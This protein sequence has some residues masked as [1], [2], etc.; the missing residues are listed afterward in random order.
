MG[1]HKIKVT[2]SG[3]STIKTVHADSIWH[4]IAKAKQRYPLA[5]ITKV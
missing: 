5:T 1:W 4:A 2:Q 3:E